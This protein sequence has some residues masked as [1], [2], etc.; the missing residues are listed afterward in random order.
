M[1]NLAERLYDALSEDGAVA[2]SKWSRVAIGIA[3]LVLASIPLS[4]QL[5]SAGEVSLLGGDR[6]IYRMLADIVIFGLL[7]IGAGLVLRWHESRTYRSPRVLLLL[8]TLALSTIWIMQA[9]S[10]W[11]PEITAFILPIPVAAMLATLLVSARSGLLMGVI[12]VNSAA[13]IGLAEGTTVVGI[14]VWSL[15]GVAA[16]SLMTQRHALFKSAGMLSLAGLMAALLQALS[17][18]AP[19]TSAI[20]SAGHGAIGGVLTVVLAYGSRP[21]LEKAFGI[22]TDVSLM[23]LTDPAHPLLRELALKAPGTYSHSMMTGNLA[24]TAAQVIG[25]RPLLARAGAYYHD[26]GKIKRPDFF[27]ENQASGPNPH[28]SRL[29]SLSA[30]IITA[31]VREGVELARSHRLPLEVVDIIQQHHGTSL[32]TYFYNK[33]TEGDAPVLEADFRYDGQTPRSREAALVML[34]DCAEAVAKTVK[35]PTPARIEAAVRRV[36]EVKMADGQLM[37]SQLTLADVEAV[38]QVYSKMLSCAYHSRN[39]YYEPRAVRF[40]YADKSFEPSRT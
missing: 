11:F 4:L 19:L 22:T 24:E 16:A 18:G 40:E 30:L 15:F 28:E 33:A 26:V 17:T 12:S 20:L 5:D 14:L 1:A 21:F 29:P 8:A 37:D 32:V 31:H 38:V 3:V 25:A 7:V 9:L 39:D 2:N 34:A 13:L 36:M 23:E 6:S 35:K 27:V 10:L